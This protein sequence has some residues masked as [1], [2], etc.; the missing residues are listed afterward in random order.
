MRGS[1]N[2]SVP[3][4]HQEVFGIV[5]TVGASLCN[6]NSQSEMRD[7]RGSLLGVASEGRDSSTCSETLFAFLK[8]LEEAEVAWNL[9]AH[10]EWCVGIE[11]LEVGMVV[12]G[13]RE[14][15]AM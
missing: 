11:R 4:G 7:A 8:L 14:D 6:G 1:K 9:C 10:V 3:V 5:Q 15:T 12:N 2:G 13:R